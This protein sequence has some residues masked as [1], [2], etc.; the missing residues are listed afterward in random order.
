MTWWSWLPGSLPK[1]C[2]LEESA[3]RPWMWKTLWSVL[4]DL[5]LER[6]SN[7]NNWFASNQLEM[8]CTGALQR[9]LDYRAG[10]STLEF[11]FVLI[12]VQSESQKKERTMIFLLA[13][14]LLR[15][16]VKKTPKCD[17]QS[18]RSRMR[19]NTNRSVQLLM[20][21]KQKCFSSAMNLNFPAEFPPQELGIVLCLASD[22]DFSFGGF[23]LKNH[24]S[25]ICGL[26]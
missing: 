22:Q 15:A 18:T 17:N 11:A 21:C 10:C 3:P 2:T 1:C 20:L 19:I 16:N 13:S 26:W 23:S 6:I 14:K 5:P 4:S 12:C 9:L 25:I 7:N 24:T 8:T